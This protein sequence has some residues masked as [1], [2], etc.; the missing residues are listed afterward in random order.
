MTSVKILVVEDEAQ[1]AS[2]V[3]SGL[4]EEGYAVDL[5]RD[6]LSGLEQ[7]ESGDHDAVIL[8]IMLPGRDGISIL[9]RLREASNTVPVILLTARDGR[10]ERIEGLDLGAD[11][12]ITKPFYM[13]ELLARLRSVVRRSAGQ[14][15]SVL[16]CGDLTANLL[17]HEVMRGD[18]PIELAQKEFALLIYLMRSP[19]RVLTRT[20]ILEHVWEYQFDPGSNI[21]DSYISRLRRKID[22]GFSIALIE[23][24]RGAGYRIRAAPA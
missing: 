21:V 8:D 17:T 13:D 14:G 19:G 24:V 11:D 1:I 18:Q 12:Y 23:T 15:L 20:Q 4:R 10:S 2:F 16:H 22:Q 5:C 3:E 9:R 6:G 7:A